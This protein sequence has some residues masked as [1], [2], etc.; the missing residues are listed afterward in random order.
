MNKSKLF[1]IRL[2]NQ[3]GLTPVSASTSAITA[4][5]VAL[6]GIPNT[7]NCNNFFLYW[8]LAKRYHK[9]PC[10]S[11]FTEK[12][13]AHLLGFFGDDTSNARK[14]AKKKKKRIKIN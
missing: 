8:R 7:R 1:A 9:T 5:F 2:I 6:G 10:K 3:T 13:N 14:T 11:S 12:S 4:S